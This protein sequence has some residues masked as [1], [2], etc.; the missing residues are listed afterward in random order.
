MA[1]STLLLGL[2]TWD[3][4]IDANANVAVATE[5]YAV[6]QDVASA[7]RTFLGEVWYNPQNLGIPYF[8]QILGK[9]PPA[10]LVKALE[11]A[12]ALTVPGVVSATCLLTA[13]AGRAL[14]GQIKLM[15]SDGTVAVVNASTLQGPTPWYV[16]AVSP[17]A[18][19]SQAGGP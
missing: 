14:G 18:A 3:L 12:A 7:C 1:F 9:L 17:Q 15:L 6:A 8:Q 19:G 4:T 10:S 5:P 16:T 2:N 11:E 13:L